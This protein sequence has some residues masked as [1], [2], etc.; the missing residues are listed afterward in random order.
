MPEKPR[1]KVEYSQTVS[2]ENIPMELSSLSPTHHPR[3]DNGSG[4]Q[5]GP[6]QSIGDTKG[7]LLEQ[8]VHD[9]TR[10]L[11]RYLRVLGC[12]LDEADDLSQEVFIVVLRR[13]L[14]DLGD[15][16]PPQIAAFLRETARYLFL[17]R[18]RNE[19]RRTELFVRAAD[20]LW[21]RECAQDDG[22]GRVAALRA[23]VAELHGRARRVIELVYGEDRSR[24][25]AARRLGLRE[26]GIKT[27]LQRVRRGLRECVH[28]K[29]QR[30][31]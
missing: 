12:D 19:R 20:L 18:R 1:E 8:V 3:P 28:R 4:S 27:M 17:R 30:E 15:R 31:S 13:D 21:R 7:A 9:H 16:S 14:G 26:N 29:E 10:G 2:R 22:A 23:C 5:V 25:D 6:G 24:R 11:W